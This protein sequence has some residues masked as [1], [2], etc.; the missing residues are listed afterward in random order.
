[1]SMALTLNVLAISN[2]G[3]G[4]ESVLFN[5]ADPYPLDTDSPENLIKS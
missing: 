5:T 4:F 2:Y 3:Q 1:M